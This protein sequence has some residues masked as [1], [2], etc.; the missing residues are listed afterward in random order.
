M[1]A[2]TIFCR[3]RPKRIHCFINDYELEEGQILARWEH[4]ILQFTAPAQSAGLIKG[5]I[6]FS[7]ASAARLQ[8]F[9]AQREREGLHL[10]LDGEVGPSRWNYALDGKGLDLGILGELSGLSIPMSGA[11]DL[12]IIGRG[13]A[14]HP[15]VEGHARIY[16]GQIANV[17]YESGE[18]DLIWQEDRITFQNL[19]LERRRPLF[20]GRRRRVSDSLTAACGCRAA[21]H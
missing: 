7:T 19:R 10:D 9:A 18:T 3:R 1:T 11:V 17:H 5:D 6:N 15:N 4:G 12:K 14:E 20:R 16:E 8:P 2:T 21:G 13:D